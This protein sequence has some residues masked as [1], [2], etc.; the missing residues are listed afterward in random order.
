MTRKPFDL[1]NTFNLVCS[2]AGKGSCEGSRK[3]VTRASAVR[4]I[5]PTGMSA[6]PPN[7]EVNL[8]SID[9]NGFP[10]YESLLPETGRETGLILHRV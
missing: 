10:K 1:C 5:L 3:R 8:L 4:S 7:M 2:I 6:H 9:R